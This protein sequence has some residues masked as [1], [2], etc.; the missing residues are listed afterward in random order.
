MYVCDRQNDRI[1][2]FKK[3]GTFVKEAFVSKTTLGEGAVW[4]IAFSSDPQQRFLYVADGS[5]SEGL[6]PAPRHA[7]G[8]RRASATAAGGRG[9]SSVSAASRWT[10]RA[11]S[12]RAR[13]TR[14]SGAEVHLQGLARRPETSHDGGTCSSAR[15]FV[16]ALAGARRRAADARPIGGGAGDRA[17]AAVR[18]RSVLA[19]AAAEPLGPRRDDRPRHRRAGSRLDRASRRSA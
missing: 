7:R 15:A 1:Q 8:R 18:G 17:G 13:P 5:R 10:R 6:R 4:D 16:A 12:T 11:T 2:V 9:T 19:E 14:A 3:D